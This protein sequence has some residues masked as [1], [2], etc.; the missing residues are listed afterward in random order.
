MRKF[1]KPTAWIKQEC[2]GWFMLEPSYSW[3]A[4]DTWGNWVASGRT[5]KDCEANCRERGYVPRRDY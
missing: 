5:R 2:T 4:R 3:V 1:A